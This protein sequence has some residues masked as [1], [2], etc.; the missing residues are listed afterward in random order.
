MTKLLGN[1]RSGFRACSPPATMV[2]LDG[3]PAETV[4]ATCPGEPTGTSDHRSAV[5]PRD[6][7]LRPAPPMDYLDKPPSL[8]GLVPKLRASTHESCLRLERR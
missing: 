4:E 1:G 8:G 2:Q 6:A 3:L 5:W 7:P